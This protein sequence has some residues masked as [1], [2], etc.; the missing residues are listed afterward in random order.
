MRFIASKRLLSFPVHSVYVSLRFKAS[1]CLYNEMP[2][3][4]TQ[5]SK[6]LARR[7]SLECMVDI[8]NWGASWFKLIQPIVDNCMLILDGL[9]PCDCVWFRRYDSRTRSIYIW[10][11]SVSLHPIFFLYH[12]LVNDDELPVSQLISWRRLFWGHWLIMHTSLLYP[13]QKRRASR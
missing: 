5:F 2:K 3:L 7:H 4:C 6:T 8:F 11:S 13:K 10:L 1:R 12:R 9:P